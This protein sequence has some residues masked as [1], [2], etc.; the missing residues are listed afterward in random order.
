VMHV[1]PGL[2]QAVA[3]AHSADCRRYRTWR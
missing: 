2:S 1:G 3:R